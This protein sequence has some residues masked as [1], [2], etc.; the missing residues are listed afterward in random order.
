[1]YNI[2]RLLINSNFVFQEGH[3]LKLA[4]Q[5]R[6]VV[7]KHLVIVNCD[8]AQLPR[9]YADVVDSHQKPVGKLVEVFGNI[10]NPCAAVYCKDTGNCAINEKLYTK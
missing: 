5:I 7:G 10:K 4:G 8:S 9:L 3:L 2:Y 6:S 1:M